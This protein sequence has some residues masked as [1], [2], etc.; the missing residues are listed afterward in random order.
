LSLP[1]H[2]LALGF[3][4]SASYGF[5]APPVGGFTYIGQGADP[6]IYV[7][8]LNWWPFALLHHLPLFHTDYIDAPFGRGLAWRTS[9]PA[10]SLLAA[11]VTLSRGAL[12]SYNLLMAC[13]PGLAGWGAY[14]AAADLCGAFWPAI[15]AGLVFAFS[16]YEMGQMQGHLNLSF[17]AAP[18]LA[19]LVVVRAAR[20]G[21]GAWRLGLALGVLLAFQF[22]VSQE[23]FATLILAGAFS[24]ACGYF[25]YP[26]WREVLRRILPGFAV[27]LLVC[28][29]LISPLIYE[30]LR[31]YGQEKQNFVSP[32]EVSTDLASL[33]I[34][35]PLYLFGGD[36][37]TRLTS[38]FGGNYS[39]D[40]GYFGI[41][42][43]MLL[44]WVVYRHR[45]VA[46]IAVSAWVALVAG[47]LSLGPVVHV[48][49]AEIFPGPWM[50]FY[51]L[52]LIAAALPARLM[53]YAWLAV[54]MLLAV[55]L[56]LPGRVAPR[57]LALL[58]CL[59]FLIPDRAYVRRWTQVNLP[60][61][62]AASAPGRHIMVLPYQGYEMAY[63]YASGMD[64]K[65]AAQGYLGIGVPAPFSKWPLFPAL[66][67]NHL[68][69]IEPAEFDT[70]LGTYGVDAV[71]VDHNFADAG[72][73]ALLA[74]AGW[75][76][77]GGDAAATIY[78]PGAGAVRPS[79][80]DAAGYLAAAQKAVDAAH[81]AKLARFERK[82][83]CQIRGVARAV[84]MDP[85]TMLDVYARLAKPPLPVDDVACPP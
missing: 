44:G 82:R 64:F 19:L 38:R 29:M 30:M 23:V 37:F 68:A 42:F 63:Q 84:G 60:A 62:F 40:G 16:G 39:E 77:D 69:A 26:G 67:K 71:V 27:A 12:S 79:A 74:K 54:A 58:A 8:F 80:A 43:L 32:A 76:A 52:P 33:I 36:F 45:H 78:R 13:A 4:L 11:F 57:Y 48:L 1:R 22:G 17:V 18:P 6:L 41:L 65:L 9:M 24:L 20:R 83:V 28:L 75:V 3:F 21:W 34:P 56:A 7:W 35:T 51:K 55:W 31:T 10:L 61:M 47:M 2:L 81:A 73:A 50:I 46:V 5:Y 72:A 85:K 49:G 70:F 59:M 66:Y 14:L 15:V 25:L 53:M